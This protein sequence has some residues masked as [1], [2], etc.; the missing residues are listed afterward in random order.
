MQL[1]HAYISIII[2][3]SLN[4]YNHCYHHELKIDR[5]IPTLLT[6]AAGAVICR[7][8]RIFLCTWLSARGDLILGGWFLFFCGGSVHRGSVAA[9]LER[10]LEL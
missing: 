3:L 8:G 5:K 10:T 4:G 9:V 2:I 7:G 6:V 1:T